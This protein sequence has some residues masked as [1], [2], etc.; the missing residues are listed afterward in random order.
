MIASFALWNPDQFVDDG[1]RIE[2]DDAREL[3]KLDHVN[4]TLFSLDVRDERLMSTQ[5]F[6]DLG[7]VHLRLNPLRRQELRQALMSGSPD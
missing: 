7:L 5:R 3:Q 2:P 1:V 4:S 6:G